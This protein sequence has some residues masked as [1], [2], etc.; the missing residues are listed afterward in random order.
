MWSASDIS[1]E[2]NKAGEGEGWE[3]AVL[4]GVIQARVAEG[5]LPPRP[6]GDEEM[7]G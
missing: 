7:R 3:L 4:H 5:N 2:R 1:L 6:E